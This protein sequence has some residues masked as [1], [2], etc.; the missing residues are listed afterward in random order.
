MSH[1]KTIV[2]PGSEGR[3]D[4]GMLRFLSTV[5]MVVF[6]IGVA[7]YAII[8]RDVWLSGAWYQY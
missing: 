3:I 8:A 7:L 1:D 5:L 2:H 6:L 4:R